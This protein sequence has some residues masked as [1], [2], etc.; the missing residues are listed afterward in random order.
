[1]KFP[2]REI[3]SVKKIPG[4]SKFPSETFERLKW[5]SVKVLSILCSVQNCDITKEQTKQ[6]S[7]H[8]KWT[9]QI[10]KRD[11]K[12]TKKRQFLWTSVCELLIE[13]N[14]HMRLIS[15]RICFLCKT[16]FICD[17]YRKLETIS[18]LLFSTPQ[19][20]TEL[21]KI[22]KTFKFKMKYHVKLKILTPC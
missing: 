15:Y 12:Q 3:Y 16:N 1:M 21:F 7:F 4:K 10:F 2:V 17:T 13:E 19:F 18:F 20:F 9:K 5:S 22:S 11:K 14:V 6:K 8:Q